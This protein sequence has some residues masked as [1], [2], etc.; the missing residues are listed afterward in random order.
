MS[1]Y[2]L[3]FV[4]F[5][6]SLTLACTPTNLPVQEF[7]RDAFNLAAQRLDLP[8]L[9][10]NDDN[11]DLKPGAG[12]IASLTFF[13]MEARWM[14]DR[15]LTPE[16]MKALTL[17]AVE[18]E[19]QTPNSMLEPG[20]VERRRLVNEELDQARPTLVRANLSTLTEWEGDMLDH[21]WVAG[22]MIDRLY[23]QQLGIE[24]LENQLAADH[25]ASRRLFRRN[26]GP[27]CIAPKT[28]GNEQCSA[29]AKAIQPA[30]GVY[31][32]S[33]DSDI[34][35]IIAEHRDAE[36]LTSPFTAVADINGELKAVP[37]PQAFSEG[38][39][40]VS[41]ELTQAAALIPEGQEDALRR[42]LTDAASAFQNND[43]PSADEAWAAMN[44]HNSRWYLRIAPDETYWE[45][46]SLKAGFHFTLARIDPSS[47][48]WQ[49]RLSP[50]RSEME[51]AIADLSGKPYL[52]RDVQFDLPDFLELIANFGDDRSP[53][54][55]TA[56]Q[57]LPNWGA[58][59]NEGRGRTV[60]MTNLGTDP[61]SRQIRRD[62]LASIVDAETLNQLSPQS[63]KA[64]AEL[65]NTILHEAAHNFGPAHEYKVTGRIDTEIFGGNL[66]TIMEELKA[67]T[68]GL[69]LIDF[70][71]TRDIIT[72][73]DAYEAYGAAFAWSM[74]HISRG[75]QT[76]SGHPRAYSQLAAIQI[77]Y[78]L[79]NGAISFDPESTAA[80]GADAGAFHINFDALPRAWTALSEEVGRIKAQGL[81]EKAASL[82]DRFVT[83]AT[84]PF[85]VI[86]TRTLRHPEPTFVYT[87]ER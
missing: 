34:C 70:L 31:P 4:L 81:S 56:G 77:G 85:E 46:C 66:A 60:A 2:S 76:P 62:Q 40:K 16:F 55:G 44:A 5:S 63:P 29:F 27:G 80:N 43:W 41:E 26:H 51:T 61:D 58:V 82:R 71:K 25:P 10:V 72:Q 23:S 14:E 8:L 1:R 84:V 39:T 45:P 13:D 48:S 15:E 36:F 42:Y 57:S 69:W 83:G 28:Q 19:N 65:L 18:I 87:K 50:L 73:A 67:Q 68:F 6:F 22:Q 54:G 49:E 79:E 12:E 33:I 78:L 86:T 32:D 53:I 11:H 52:A 38:M 74:R 9:W 20:E 30:V 47:I 24:G 7:D 17:I 35:S 21:F 59:A 37:Y 3:L 64:D 75:M